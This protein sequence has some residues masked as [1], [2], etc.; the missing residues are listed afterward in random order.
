MSEIPAFI[1]EGRCRTRDGRAARLL[2]TDAEAKDKPIV[3]LVGGLPATYRVDGRYVGGESESIMD[4]VEIPAEPAKPREFWIG[5]RSID[6]AGPDHPL[7]NAYAS[8]ET[9][10][11]RVEGGH[12][13]CIRVV[14]VPP[15]WSDP[16]PPED[17]KRFERFVAEVDRLL[18]RVS[19]DELRDAFRK[20]GCEVV[21]AATPE[22]TSKPLPPGIPQ[23][24]GG[25]E[26]VGNGPIVKPEGQ[27]NDIAFFDT[28]DTISR[29]YVGGLGLYPNFHYAARIGSEI[30][31]L[32]SGE[33]EL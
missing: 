28:S 24:P 31:R 18:S 15:G 29:W 11:H 12:Q 1:L 10:D 32:N 5:S 13:K 33:V 17:H 7:Y 21:S 22:P 25:F 9:A 20:M 2:C 27:S 30:H 4:L 3:A 14:E 16:R 19:D 8:R 26:Y 6:N 23:P